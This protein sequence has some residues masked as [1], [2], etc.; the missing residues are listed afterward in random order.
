MASSGVEALSFD[1][2]GAEKRVPAKPSSKLSTVVPAFTPLSP[3]T[4]RSMQLIEIFFLAVLASS[5][6]TVLKQATQDEA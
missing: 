3:P 6:A 2:I 4:I 1:I 5:S